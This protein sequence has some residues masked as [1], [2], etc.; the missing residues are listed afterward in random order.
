[1]DLCATFH[2]EATADYISKYNANFHEKKAA[3]VGCQ[4]KRLTK[5]PRIAKFHIYSERLAC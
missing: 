3:A 4:Q 2:T 1:M 5:H